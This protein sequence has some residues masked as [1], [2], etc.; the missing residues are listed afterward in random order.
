VLYA[1][2]AVLYSPKDEQ[3]KKKKDE[4][5]DICKK[6]HWRSFKYN[7][8]GREINYEFLVLFKT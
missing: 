5:N 1:H 2:T 6:I 4:Q 8:I 3:N 7:E